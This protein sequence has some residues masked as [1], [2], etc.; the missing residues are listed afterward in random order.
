MSFIYPPLEEIDEIL[1]LAS[2][3]SLGAKLFTKYR[4]FVTFQ[5]Q[6]ALYWKIH[7]NRPYA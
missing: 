5:N 3:I 2:N 1:I 7:F 4:H 6:K